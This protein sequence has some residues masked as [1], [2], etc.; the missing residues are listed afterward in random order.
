MKKI[1]L[2]LAMAVATVGAAF[3]QQGQMAAGINLGVVPS[4]E[5][6]LK[7]TNFQLGAKFQYG[8]TDAI[9]GEVDLEYGFKAKGISVFDVTVNGHYLI[10]VADNF[11]IYPLVGLGYASLTQDL[12]AAIKGMSFDDFLSMSGIS[13]NEFNQLPGYAKDQSEDLYDETLGAAGKELK[14]KSESV[15]RFVFNIG[16][17]GEYDL[18]E[19]L[20]LNLEIKYQYMKDFNRMPILLGVAYKF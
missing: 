6:N 12:G 15:S 20:S 2:T 7:A 9:R 11:K 13:Q 18:T 10:P 1:L 4:L 19:N 16:V 3:A 8:I 17:G 5:S 14:G